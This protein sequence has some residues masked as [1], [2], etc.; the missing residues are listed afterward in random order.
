MTEFISAAGLASY[1]GIKLAESEIPAIVIE[2]INELVDDIVVD[3][4]GI[5][6]LDSIPAKIRSIALKAAARSI[7]YADGASSISTAID[8]WK[9]TLRFEGEDF[10]AGIYLTD[11]E[12]AKIRAVLLGEDTPQAGSIRVH[13]PGYGRGSYSR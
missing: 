11:D 12:E 6:E 1:P 13:V 8:D 3:A 9:K 10:E 4:T 5:T 2:L 7:L